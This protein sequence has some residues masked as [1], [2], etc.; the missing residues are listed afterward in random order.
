MLDLLRADARAR[1]LAGQRLERAQDWLAGSSTP[2]SAAQPSSTSG[3][4]AESGDGRDRI[5]VQ[6]IYGVGRALH[7]DVSVNG[8]LWRYRGAGAALGVND[9][10]A[11]PRY[12]LASIDPLLRAPALGR[13]CR[14]HRLLC[15]PGRPPDD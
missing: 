4:Q 12:A 11:E 6:A 9:P 3:A 2:S 1:A 10:A 8:A 5:D 7:A 13:R 15:I 14:A